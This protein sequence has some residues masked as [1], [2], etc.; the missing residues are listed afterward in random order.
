MITRPIPTPK[1]KL[2][3]TRQSEAIREL[4]SASCGVPHSYHKQE[5]IKPL[6][7]SSIGTK[8]QIRE[9]LERT[10]IS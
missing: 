2:K 9:L 4:L 5:S 7:G 3:N 8:Q 1:L 10:I 6:R